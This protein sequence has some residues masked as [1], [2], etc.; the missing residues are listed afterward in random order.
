MSLGAWCGAFEHFVQDELVTIAP[1]K[2]PYVGIEEA[3]GMPPPLFGAFYVAIY[4]AGWRPLADVAQCQR[5]EEEFDVG[6]AITRKTA[7]FPK[8]LFD[9][10]VWRDQTLGLEPLGRRIVC[11]LMRDMY[12][13]VTEAGQRIE[14]CGDVVN[15]PLEP[16]VF[17]HAEGPKSAGSEWF[18]EGAG[19]VLHLIFSGG[20]RVQD[21]T[22]AT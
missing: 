21:V 20:K 8:G 19:M 16:M 9:E 18:Q 10:K 3:P 1:T 17:S 13:V 2:Y 7:M 12:K 22:G 14:A 11:R 6:I 4:P 5:F 15:G